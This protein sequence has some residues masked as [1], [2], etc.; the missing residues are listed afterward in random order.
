MVLDLDE[1][2]YTRRGITILLT[3]TPPQSLHA[4][5]MAPYVECH[6]PPR[7]EGACARSKAPMHNNDATLTSIGRSPNLATGRVRGLANTGA[8]TER[9]GVCGGASADAE[10][11]AE[12]DAG[13]GVGAGDEVSMVAGP[14]GVFVRLGVED[15]DAKSCCVKRLRLG[16]LNGEPS[17][18]PARDMA[19]RWRVGGSTAPEIMALLGTGK[20]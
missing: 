17:P 11:D 10:V 15:G 3:Y 18:P 4:G 8:G 9:K 1:T 14:S 5:L 19:V 16:V 12:A 20:W 13:P 6:I 2:S 7:L